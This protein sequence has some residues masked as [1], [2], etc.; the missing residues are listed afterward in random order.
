MKNKSDIFMFILFLGGG[1]PEPSPD[2]SGK[3]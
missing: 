2:L 3:V 1:N